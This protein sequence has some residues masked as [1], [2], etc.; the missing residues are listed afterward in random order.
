MKQIIVQYHSVCGG[1]NN[2]QTASIY[3]G[4]SL[5]KRFSSRKN[6]AILYAE[7]YSEKLN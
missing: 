5:I 4:E 3:H 1:I 2:L 6:R 7:K